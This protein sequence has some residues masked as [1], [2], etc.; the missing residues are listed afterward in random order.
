MNRMQGAILFFIFPLVLI[1]QVKTPFVTYDYQ[2]DSRY[3]KEL[4]FL[5]KKESGKSTAVIRSIAELSYY[6]NDWDTAI[7]YYK[8]LIVNVPQ[9]KIILSWVLLPPENPWKLPS[10]F[11]SL[12]WLVPENRFLKRMRWNPE[13]KYF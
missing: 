10:F 2:S 1:S 6:Y 9:L 13:I 5:K 7:D 4:E 11:L 8:R 3:K 12:T